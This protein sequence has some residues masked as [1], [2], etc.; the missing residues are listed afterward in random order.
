MTDKEQNPTTSTSS[1]QQGV[2][3]QEPKSPMV[4]CKEVFM[5][6]KFEALH[7]SPEERC[8]YTADRIRSGLQSLRLAFIVFITLFSLFAILD[9]FLVGDYFP[10]F[11]IIRFGIVIPLMIISVIL[12]FLPSFYKFAQPLMVLCFVTGGTGI[13]YM[14]ILCPENFSYYGGIFL[15]IFSGYFLIKLDTPHALFGG[16]LTL[17]LYITGYVWHYGTLNMETLMVVFFFLGA[18][19]IGALGNYQMEKIGKAN[20]L[21][22]RKIQKQNEQLQNRV[23]AQKTELLQVEKAID[24]TSDAV[25]IYNPLGIVIY[26]NVAYKSLMRPFAFPETRV[27]YV[28][29]DILEKVLTG[30][31]WKGERTVPDTTGA[32]KVLLIQTDAVHEENG[33]IAGIVTTYRD[34]TA[35]KQAEKA[36]R[37]SEARLKDLFDNMPNGYYLSTKEGKFVDANPAFVKMLGYSS[38][39]ELLQ[40]DIPQDLFAKPEERG[41]YVDEFLNPEFLSINFPEFYS[42]KTKDGRIIQVEDNSRYIK[43]EKGNILYHEGICR[44]ITERE[45]AEEKLKASEQTFRNIVQASPMG[46][47]L[48]RLDNKQRLIFVGTNPAADRLLKVDNKQFIGKTF[49]EAFPMFIDTEIPLR[50]QRAADL[51]ENWQ[52]EHI[53]Y[54]D[55]KMT[56]AFEVY[57]FQMSPGNTA[58]LFNEITSR[59]QAEEERQ[60]LQLQLIHSQKMESV[61][62][63]AGGVAHDFN[64]ML[65]VILGHTELALQVLGSSQPLYK[66]MEEIRKAASRSVDLTKQLLAFARKQTVAPK[67]LSLNET[68]EG[69][70]D[71]LQRLIGENIDLIWR[72]ESNIANVKIDPS[73]LDQILANL[74]INARDAIADT[75]SIAIETGNIIIDETSTSEKIEA[76]PGRYVMLTISDSGCGMDAETLSHLFEPF[77]TTKGIGKGTGL[78]LATVYGI[79]KQNNGYIDLQSEEGKGTTFK[80]FLPSCDMEKEQPTD[81]QTAT[82]L[83]GVETILLVEDE[84]MI[85]EMT[86][87]LLEKLGYQV[88]AYNSPK[89]AIDFTKQYGDDI[90]LLL[91]DVIMPEMNGRDL[92]NNVLP[93]FP[94]LKCLF[95]SGYTDD[96]I[97]H[98][99]V[100]DEGTSFIQKPFT[101][102]DL[103]LKIRDTLNHG[104]G[105]VN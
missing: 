41:N 6:V 4:L 18:N 102:S 63:L 73:Q 32:K 42:L 29:E 14:L 49:E 13:G 88:F 94:N 85:L 69:M 105:E 54:S 2:R 78:G 7:L 104:S 46:I 11:L 10:T 59:K 87:K 74:C 76:L 95:M 25:V 101:R 92:A 65:G 52:T 47:H 70:L 86:T 15:I 24:S 51:G 31:S 20:F 72:P 19:I 90:H 84:A 62:R 27:P 3:I 71:M 82:T 93:R 22:K 50:C 58:V 67:V 80:I 30:E 34:I 21:H 66:S 96:I 23:Q 38:R 45:I 98:H 99:G 28:F 100:L 77:F 60:Q 16:L 68:V 26:R 40:V 8:A 17:L 103:S 9:Y 53:V 57:V 36:L 35:Q 61:G 75:G 83:Q 89:A 39:E 5:E 64:N 12:T 81:N 33:V 44:D 1:D 48:H 91:T 79:V 43:D 56:D 97:A 37:E 55:G